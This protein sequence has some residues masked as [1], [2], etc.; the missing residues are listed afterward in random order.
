MISNLTSGKKTYLHDSLHSWVLP[1]IK[2]LSNKSMGVSVSAKKLKIC[3]ILQPERYKVQVTINEAVIGRTCDGATFMRYE[4]E[5]KRQL[6]E[7]GFWSE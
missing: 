3:G 2:A 1:Q 6:R 5:V 7:Y 4:R